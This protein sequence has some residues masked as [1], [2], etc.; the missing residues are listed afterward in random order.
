MGFRTCWR[1]SFVEDARLSL[2]YNVDM[3]SDLLPASSLFHPNTRETQML[4]PAGVRHAS[5]P[6]YGFVAGDD[7]D[8]A[9]DPHVTRPAAHTT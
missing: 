9:I 2:R 3:A 4:R 8:V 1:S 7:G 6:S 5:A